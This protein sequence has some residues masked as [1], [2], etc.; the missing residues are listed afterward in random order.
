MLS[1]T[2]LGGLRA[3]S[4]KAP[5]FMTLS[6]QTF[7]GQELLGSKE[8]LKKGWQIKKMACFFFITHQKGFTFHVQP[9]TGAY[10]CLDQQFGYKM[11]TS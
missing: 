2:C 9:Q 3:S 10:S 7:R 5:G 1:F 6:T 4:L 8:I 11:G